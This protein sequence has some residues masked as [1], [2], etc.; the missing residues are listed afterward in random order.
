M[1]MQRMVLEFGMGTDISGADPI[2]AA[3]QA[4]QDVLLHNVL[5]IAT[6]LG[7][8]PRVLTID[9]HIGV[10]HPDQVNEAWVLAALPP[11]KGRVRVVD[12]GLDVPDAPSLTTPP[13]SPLR[14]SPCALT[15]SRWPRA[16]NA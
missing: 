11:C 3:L 1:A 5:S 14:P 7:Q 8:P 16:V 13:A 15:F 4:L 9:A 12:G 6:A 10:T 2:Q